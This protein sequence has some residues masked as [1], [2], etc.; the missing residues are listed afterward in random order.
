M[1]GVLQKFDGAIVIAMRMTD[2]DVL[3]IG[4]VETQFL[5]AIH[6]FVLRGVA[7]QGIDQNDAG[8]SLHGPGAVG[9]CG[10]HIEVV[11]NLPTFG[12]P[13]LARRSGA[14]SAGTA[15]LRHA[16]R[17][18]A[19]H[20]GPDH[21]PAGWRSAPG[22]WQPGRQGAR[23]PCYSSSAKPSLQ[24]CEPYRCRLTDQKPWRSG[25]P[26]VEPNGQSASC[27]SLSHICL[28]SAAPVP[29]SCQSGEIG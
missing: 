14:T 7:E 10:Q 15:A 17:P 22:R 24:L 16:R 11:K 1:V 12:V 23:L 26:R 9:L 25:T 18:G 8:G 21:R 2:D 6:D 4:R 28:P 20:L 19:P 5:H 3:D 13:V 27:D 29:S